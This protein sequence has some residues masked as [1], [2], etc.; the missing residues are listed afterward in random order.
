M[1]RNSGLGSFPSLEPEVTR[2]ERRYKRKKALLFLVLCMTCSN[3]FSDAP[4]EDL[5]MHFVCTSRGLLHPCDANMYKRSDP[6]V[7]HLSSSLSN[8]C[9]DITPAA[10]TITA[11]SRSYKCPPSA[12]QH[13]INLTNLQW[14]VFRAENVR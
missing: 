1:G 12:G 13:N 2:Q 9:T 5:T 7:K 10:L 3:A 4:R 6:G 11:G 14:R 8:R